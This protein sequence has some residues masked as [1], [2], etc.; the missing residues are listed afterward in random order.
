MRV[1]V[2]I[3]GSV[4][5]FYNVTGRRVADALRTL[6]CDVDVHT[7]PSARQGEY[8]WCLA[9]DLTEITQAWGDKREAMR[10]FDEVRAECGRTAVILQECVNTHWFIDASGLVA[11]AGVDTVLDLGL[12]DQTDQ[13]APS[14]A[15]RYRFVLN[16]LT[17][18]E[19]ALARSMPPDS[20]DRPIPWVFIG[21]FT[22]TRAALVNRLVNEVDPGGFV[23]LP[24]LDP[25]TEDG[26]HINAS[27]LRRVLERSRYQVWCAHHSHFHLE[28]E[29]FR[30]SLLA[31]GVPIKIMLGPATTG[32]SVPFPY[33][34]LDE[35]HFEQL[36][37]E[38]DFEAA[39]A[40]FREEFF[41]LPTLEDCLAEVVM[42]NGPT[43]ALGR[44]G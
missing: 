33:L 28:G 20:E 18:R 8:D 21:H 19:H 25:V 5:Y 2:L 10:R 38:M 13:L 24:R 14:T 12:N 35:Q 3:P 42:T 41:A 23:Y 26:P 31:G 37:R 27:Q 1:L 34:M 30:N 15:T 7:L 29:R 32:A 4:S 40:Q 11:E 9:V 17:R 39:R 36:L 16:G 6:G 44:P 43:T 22:P